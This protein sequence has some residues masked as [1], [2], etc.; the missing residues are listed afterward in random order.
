MEGQLGCGVPDP[1]QSEEGIYIQGKSG[2]GF[3]SLSRMKKAS[4]WERQTGVGE[5]ESKCI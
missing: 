5:L 3:Q 4:M 2:M 1:E